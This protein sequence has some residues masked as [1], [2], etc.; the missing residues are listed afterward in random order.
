MYCMCKELGD[1]SSYLGVLNDPWCVRGW[2]GQ[3][4][5]AVAVTHAQA[6]AEAE[7]EEAAAL[8]AATASPLSRPA[9][10]L[11]SAALL[12]A[13]LS[14]PPPPG[15]AEVAAALG[16]IAALGGLSPH[17]DDE[18]GQDGTC[19]SAQ[20]IVLAVAPHRLLPSSRL[21]VS[22]GCHDVRL[23]CGRGAAPPGARADP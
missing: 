17:D 18:T 11:A 7:E 16:K 4:E 23:P 20:R 8:A 3:V 15:V 22:V 1:I 5:A 21:I 13:L 12:R 2:C 10:S 9:L 19:L 14:A 6:T